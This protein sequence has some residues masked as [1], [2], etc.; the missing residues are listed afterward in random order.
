MGAG[1]GDAGLFTRKGL[2]CVRQADVIVY[3]NLISGSILNEA[4][5]DAEL[6]YAGKRSGQHH[7]TQEEIQKLLVELAMEGKSVVRL[8]GGDPY[9]FGRGGEEA[10][11]LEDVYKRQ[12]LHCRSIY[13]FWAGDCAWRLSWQA[14]VI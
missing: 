2:E 14:T 1:P 4:R 10:L 5:L 9:V 7:M 6:I 13:G 11:E 8:K 3:D 12:E